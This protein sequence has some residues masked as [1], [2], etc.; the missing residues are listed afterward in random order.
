MTIP[1]SSLSLYYP[2][3]SNDKQFSV[4][5]IKVGKKQLFTEAESDFQLI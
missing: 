4:D 3:T 1:K 2:K 5:G